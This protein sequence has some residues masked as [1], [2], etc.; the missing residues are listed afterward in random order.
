MNKKIT[1]AMGGG[2]MK[3]AYGYGVLLALDNI[4]SNFSL[5]SI[6]NFYGVSSGAA[7]ITYY[8][9]DQFHTNGLSIWTKDLLTKKFIN[10]NNY[11][12]FFFGRKYIDID[13][14]CYNVFQKKNPLNMKKFLEKNTSFF[15]PVIN[16]NTCE[17]EFFT[18]K[19]FKYR[20]IDGEKIKCSKIS[21]YNI[22]EVLR[23]A[24][25]VPIVFNKA[26]K[27]NK[28]YYLDGYFFD[29]P[30]ID[31]IDFK[32]TKKIVV[33]MD[34][35]IKKIKKSILLEIFVYLFKKFPTKNINKYVYELIKIRDYKTYPKKEK[36]LMLREKNDE[37][38]IFRPKK[39]YTL[40]NNSAKSMNSRVVDG[41]CDTMRRK[42]EFIKWL[43][44]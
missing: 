2:S 24:T 10:K 38:F 35:P 44:K 41:Y 9:A 23:A 16:S 7:T 17:L 15:I 42:D 37:I 6:S 30:V 32:N 36:E 27:I 18:N 25:G 20:V 21:K 1:L 5:K 8:L 43:K 31:I 22:Y 29:P 40:F 39:E 14:L 34:P 13:Y 19:T 28:E 11:L 4:S 33:L 12:R 26:T 3:G